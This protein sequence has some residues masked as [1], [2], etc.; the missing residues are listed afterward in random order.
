MDWARDNAELSD[1]D[2]DNVFKYEEKSTTVVRM[3]ADEKVQSRDLPGAIVRAYTLIETDDLV[4]GGE[5]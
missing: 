4:I 1:K 3:L 5:G 2:L